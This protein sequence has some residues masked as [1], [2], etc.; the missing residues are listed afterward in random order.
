MKT[1]FHPKRITLIT[2]LSNFVIEKIII[3]NYNECKF[4]T[5]TKKIASEHMRE[6]VFRG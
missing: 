6:R 5:F 3:P 1:L 4:L 2:P